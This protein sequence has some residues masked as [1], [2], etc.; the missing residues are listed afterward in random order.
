M[1]RIKKLSQHA[2]DRARERGITDDDILSVL[3]NPSLTRPANS[4]SKL[5]YESGPDQDG[6]RI[7]VVASHPPDAHD[8]VVVV[9]C[10]KR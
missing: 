4:A 1:P 3:L 5:V 7:V 2:R 8:C 6:C 10:W 9:S